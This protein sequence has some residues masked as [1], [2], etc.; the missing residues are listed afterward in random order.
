MSALRQ[1][2]AAAIEAN[3]AAT[4][5]C[6]NAQRAFATSRPDPQLHAAYIA[7]KEAMALRR[8][9]VRAAAAA[10]LVDEFGSRWRAFF[11]VAVQGCQR[12]IRRYDLSWCADGRIRPPVKETARPLAAVVG[13]A[14]QND[15]LRARHHFQKTLVI[16]R[17]IAAR[18]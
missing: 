8:V 17:V 15:D 2:P 1:A 3:D 6:T 5:A 7:A 18:A 12:A 11:E 13:P 9:D 16:G 10:V 4:P 14:P